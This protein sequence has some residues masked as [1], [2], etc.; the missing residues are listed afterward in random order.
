MPHEPAREEEDSPLFHSDEFR[1][2]CMKASSAGWCAGTQLGV[3][4][5]HTTFAIGPADPVLHSVLS[6]LSILSAC[7]G[8]RVVP[9][10]PFE[11]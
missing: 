11:N 4:A 8:K 9:E 5:D 6:V 1:I 2:F 3:L 10:T 7:T